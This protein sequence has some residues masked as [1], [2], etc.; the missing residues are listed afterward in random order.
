MPP[1]VETFAQ[2]F[3]THDSRA[4]LVSLRIRTTAAMI[5]LS[6]EETRE[7]RERLRQLPKAQPAD[8]TIAVSANASTS[9]TFTAVQK[10][11]VLEVLDR[12]FAESG[13]PAGDLL[14]LRDA[15][16]AD[17]ESAV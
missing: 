10:A 4:R 2:T 5:E 1:A 6:D 12:W 11:A 8:E 3:A 9:V 17:V 14:R 15:L 7:L 16:Q 13:P